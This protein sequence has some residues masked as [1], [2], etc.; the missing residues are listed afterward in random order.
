M[1]DARNPMQAFANSVYSMI[2]GP[3]T[4]FR[5]KYILPVTPYA[6]PAVILRDIQSI[7]AWFLHCQVH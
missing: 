7:V 2:D 5:G 1:P 3:I 6:T 4:W